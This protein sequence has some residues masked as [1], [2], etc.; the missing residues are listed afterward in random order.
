MSAGALA[1]ASTASPK[2]AGSPAA[3]PA[4]SAAP[5]VSPTA[6]PDPNASPVRQ[7]EIDFYDTEDA[8]AAAFTAGRIDGASGL[9]PATTEALGASAGTRVLDYPTTTLSAILLNLRPTHPELADPNVRTALLLAIDRATIAS[10]DLGGQA[11]VADALVPPESWTYDAGR[12]AEN[13]YNPS[14]SA[15]LL[16]AAGWTKP[17]GK[18]TAPKAKAPYAI[19][20]LTVPADVN[21]RLAAVAGAVKD[22]WT[23]LGLSVSVTP[24]SGADLAARLKA[25][26]F[27]AAVLDIA[28]G[29]EP[30][31]YPLLDSTQVRANGSNR[32]GYQDPALD[33]LLEAARRNGTM[34]QRKAA[35]S[36]LLAGLSARM[37]V[38]PIIWADE[39]MV[40]R[41]LSGNTPRLI[42][43]TGDRFWDVLAWRLAASR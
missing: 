39:Q 28:S 8:L 43:R 17:G 6:S 2:P 15:K 4:A 27:S 19:E 36:A 25:G 3:S 10:T 34:A 33:K 29:L 32:S 22:D 26:T 21:P 16:R 11:R 35:W 18:W 24:L 7:I 1:L 5:T 37:P 9:T 41:G 31:L 23:K 12:V 20:L 42:A 13:P 14:L 38:L 30:D 40:V